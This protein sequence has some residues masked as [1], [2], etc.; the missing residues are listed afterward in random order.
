MSKRSLNEGGLC[1]RFVIEI[2]QALQEKWI[3]M[4]MKERGIL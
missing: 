4:F 3:W 1:L 2:N